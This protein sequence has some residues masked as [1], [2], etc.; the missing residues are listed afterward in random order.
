[1]YQAERAVAAAL[2]VLLTA[3]LAAGGGCGDS[4]S[5]DPSMT[6]ASEEAGSDEPSAGSGAESTSSSGGKS[7][8]APGSSSA[9]SSAAGDNCIPALASEKLR[10]RES[11]MLSPLKKE[12]PP[13][14]EQVSV[15]DLFDAFNANCGQC[16]VDRNDGDLQ[17]TAST[18]AAG[19]DLDWVRSMKSNSAEGQD[20]QPPYMPPDGY[21]G[22]PY[23]E[24]V[25][26]GGDAITQLA[27]RIEA[28]V[29]QGKP[30]TFSAPDAADA[31]TSTAYLASPSVGIQMTNMG[32]C[33]PDKQM[34]ARETDRS[35]ELDKVF[36]AA[37]EF[38]DLPG[39]LDQ[40]D[41]FTFDAKELA[42]HGV[43]AY[44]PA[45]TLWA[46]NAKKLRMVRVPRGE[47]I[48]FDKDAQEF[49]IPPNT[50]IYKT[51]FKKVTD[52]TGR[53]SY[54]KMETRL[55][56][57]RPDEKLADGSRRVR[58]LFGT[59]AWNDAETEA[60]LVRD[61]LR[62]G[63]PFR[64]RF[65]PYVTDEKAAYD[66]I[67]QGPLDNDQ[68]LRDAHLIRTYAIPGSE[69]CIQ[70]HMGSYPGNFTLGF[71]PLQ[72]HRRPQGKGGV[73]EPADR[74]ELN[75]LQR[76]I[77]YG[78]ISGM[79][80]PDDV[81]VLEDSQGE[82][83]PRNEAE[84]QAQGYM[85]GN[86]AHC[87]NPYGF[88]SVTAPELKD[89]LNFLP[90]TPRGGIFQFP[91]DRTSPRIL[92]GDLQNIPI[93]YITPSLYELG[94]GEV[95]G[96]NKRKSRIGPDFP[97][98]YILAPWRSLI[99]RNVDTPF[100]YIED[101]AIYPR[102]PRHTPGYD[103]R[104]RKILGTW[105]TSIPSRL[106]IPVENPLVQKTFVEPDPM[107]LKTLMDDEAKRLDTA[108]KD[109]ANNHQG[110]VDERMEVH[111]D[112]MDL[113]QPYQEVSPTDPDYQQ[114]LSDAAT[115]AR[116]FLDSPRHLDC[117]KPEDDI[118]DPK[119]SGTNVTRP[120]DVFVPS[121][122]YPDALNKSF[123]YTLPIPVRSHW[124]VS[125]FTDPPPP[126]QPRRADW[127]DVLVDGKSD[128]PA[129]KNMRRVLDGNTERGPVKV[130]GDDELR[131]LALEPKPFGIWADKNKSCRFPS[132]VKTVADYQ[133]Q[134]P[135]MGGKMVPQDKL[136]PNYR[137]PDK[138]DHVYE[139]AYGAQIYRTICY[140]CH[141]KNAD[142][143][144][145]NADTISDLTGG[146]TRVANFMSGV[147]G[148]VAGKGETPNE[149]P[150]DNRTRIFGVGASGGLTADDVGARYFT[151]MALGGTQRSIPEQILSFVSKSRVLGYQR[152]QPAEATSPNMLIL[153]NKLCGEILP[154]RERLFDLEHG[155]LST[156]VTSNDTAADAQSA[157]VYHT[158]E[159]EM[160]ERI[161]AHENPL[162]VRV[163]TFRSA[164][165]KLLVYNI[166]PVTPTAQG[167]Y[168]LYKRAGYGG[169][170]VGDGEG[171]VVKGISPFNKT[172]W[173]VRKID[174]D[175]NA[176]LEARWAAAHPDSKL[177]FCP[178]K[179]LGN[180][181]NR[182]T[183][184]DV[185]DW[186]RRGAINAGLAVFLYLDAV[187]KGEIKPLPDYDQCDKLTVN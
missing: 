146:N 92:R 151:W 131:K 26:R 132:S 149:K 77:D 1:M 2:T 104:V 143:I 28:F 135:W 91:L 141:G 158:G 23:D 29:E 14:P 179:F 93:A 139:I 8:S 117:Q 180:E 15:R 60:V 83:K 119:M 43:I 38:G 13:R 48:R 35:A 102:M 176:K 175:T 19:I 25:K 136:E 165:Q 178:D 106:V 182:L 57:S 72:L 100:T 111:S 55:I 169:E 4:S 128:R 148:P 70:C 36:A 137:V 145:R 172:P 173:C 168:A 127:K 39:R 125:D 163:L 51:F 21:G 107:K 138:G 85:L 109:I 86:C 126:W 114:A 17:L 101:N 147:F 118:V 76:L 186:A 140:N 112:N 11:A 80:S 45:Y 90:L 54:R 73:T 105:M 110:Y 99:Y 154:S 120:V 181:A 155:R 95:A 98:D 160:W 134:P 124:F 68:A 113:P 174:A 144:S 152:L 116:R 170:P 41:L 6:G 53:E 33:V 97:G 129:D 164:D 32:S 185:D 87:H 12:L 108:R 75:Q 61:P 66:L 10:A 56:L 79:A 162:P 81:V 157:A 177:P 20:D 24:R 59:Y 122:E 67:S 115:R 153:A 130:S 9:G 52:I 62:N 150:G 74:D 49:S 40:T 89:L 63:T 31:T 184:Q 159:G 65:V 82:R 22:L 123:Q 42:K 187:S 37:K 167:M 27:A 3:C 133:D 5:S 142:S 58:A 161:C 50:R 103:C 71:T 16:H 7:T 78:L 46:D 30:G 34:V 84:L 171:R 88:P 18:F 44:S 64:D 96:K 47:T 121:P 94:D 69:R 156:A 183:D 166:P